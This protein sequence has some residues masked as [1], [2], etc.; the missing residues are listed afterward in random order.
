VIP[1][2]VTTQITLVVVGLVILVLP[3]F[4]MVGW[5]QYLVMLAGASQ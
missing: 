1:I 3:L 4:F 2:K 5:H